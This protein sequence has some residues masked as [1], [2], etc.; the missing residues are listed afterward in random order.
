MSAQ[1]TPK[2]R[3]NRQGTGPGSQ[4]EAVPYP[5][6]TDQ[7]YFV[8]QSQSFGTG[9]QN[10]F[11]G[12]D[13]EAQ[14]CPK[15]KKCH[16]LLAVS[17][18]VPWGNRPHAT[19]VYPLFWRMTVRQDSDGKESVPGR[20]ASVSKGVEAELGVRGWAR[21]SEPG[22]VGTKTEGPGCRELGFSSRGRGT[23][24]IPEHCTTPNCRRGLDSKCADW[25]CAL[26]NVLLHSS[27][28]PIVEYIDAQFE[29]YLQEELKI[30][31]SLF[32]Y[33]D[34]RI[35]ACL[36]FIAPTGHSLKSLD[37]VT[38]KK[39]DSKVLTARPSAAR[40]SPVSSPLFQD[41]TLFSAFS[42]NVFCFVVKKK[43]FF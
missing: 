25:K 13:L 17:S 41:P 9:C 26:E 7:F 1:R 5:E 14:F 21:D 12:T 40:H 19:P 35:H 6:V 22:G 23:V 20:R 28:K 18:R 39:L 34:T 16:H 24:D 8:H 27:Y 43:T 30:K 36:Y 15:R 10:H 29:A 2:L 38:M 3:R 33:H 32:N 11:V 4:W 42:V 31:R 37:L